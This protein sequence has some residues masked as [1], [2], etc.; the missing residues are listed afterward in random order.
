MKV[1]PSTFEAVQ[2]WKSRDE[3]FPSLLFA[4]SHGET[5]LL[6]PSIPIQ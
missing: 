1:I 3:G 5:D 4:H 6:H 2:S